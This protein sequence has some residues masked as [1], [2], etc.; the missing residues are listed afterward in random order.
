MAIEH[1]AE[2]QADELKVKAK[3]RTALHP[4]APGT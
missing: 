3:R 4:V 2:G 1:T